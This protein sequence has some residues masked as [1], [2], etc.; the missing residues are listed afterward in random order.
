M[1]GMP[2]GR[3]IVVSLTI[4]AAAGCRGE[5]DAPQRKLDLVGTRAAP[6]PGPER[7]APSGTP[8]IGAHREALVVDLIQDFVFRKRR[9]GWTLSTPAAHTS[10]DRQAAGG[11]DLVLAALPGGASPDPAAALEADLADMEALVADS[12]GR[13]A[14]VRGLAAARAAREEGAL[15]ILLLLEG[16]D[17]VPARDPSPALAR[18]RERG[19]FAVGIVGERGN[20]FAD[21]AASPGD[22]GGLTDR[23]AALVR[24][25]RE[26]GMLVDLTHASRRAF[27]DALAGENAIVSV[28]HTAARSL[29][30]HARN[31]DDLQILALSRSGGVM[32]LV[33]NPDFLRAGDP[34]GASVDDV[35]A[36]ASHV[37]RLGAL[38]AL[39]LGTDFGGI[40]P[41]AG[42]ADVS[43]LPSLTERLWREGFAREEIDGILGGNALRVLEAVEAGQGAAESSAREPVRPIGAECDSVSGDH[44]GEPAGACDGTVLSGG[45]RLAASS[46][47]RV[48]LREMA[49]SPK[50]I[51]L[52][53]EAGTPWQVEGQDLDGRVLLRRIVALG[54]DGRGELP[55]PKDRNLTRLFLSPTRE[56]ALR[57]AVV[58]GR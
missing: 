3:I 1:D 13:A 26:K 10:L 39:A 23:G 44:A 11:I 18:L 16:A 40:V 37:R 24:A 25:C 17:A 50:S 51:E 48:R 2:P 57:E 35:V 55:L 34:A 52:F 36:H 6:S 38:S 33:F 47:L 9:D 19:V 56:S 53:G 41:P 31:L 29:R 45:P 54:A 14:I 15:P 30:E 32:G 43:A 58:W 46:V 27:W 22:P 12:G 7:P 49:Y 5:G 28:T 21:S 4:A 20:A 42:L 8:W